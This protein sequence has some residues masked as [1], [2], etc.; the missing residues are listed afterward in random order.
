MATHTYNDLAT[1]GKDN[2]RSTERMVEVSRVSYTMLG[3]ESATESIRLFNAPKGSVITA[4]KI[5]NDG[6]ATTCTLD[7]G[8]DSGAVDS[9]ANGIDVAAAGADDAFVADVSADG[10]SVY[11]TFATLA[12]PVAGKILTVS[13]VYDHNT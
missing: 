3:T 12:T 11:A 6:I 7:I 1:G 8:V 10:E 2:A 4:Y 5:V 13:V 9:I